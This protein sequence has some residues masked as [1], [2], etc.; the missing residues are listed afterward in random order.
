VE[1]FGQ[2]LLDGSPLFEVVV[3]GVSRISVRVYQ[4]FHGDDGA[5]AAEIVFVFDGHARPFDDSPYGGTT[6]FVSFSVTTP[7]TWGV[8]EGGFHGKCVVGG[9]FFVGV[10]F[11]RERLEIS[12]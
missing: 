7:W 8:Y 9:E 1:F 2:S 12:V 4:G 3:I 10:E 11:G 6:R 5:S